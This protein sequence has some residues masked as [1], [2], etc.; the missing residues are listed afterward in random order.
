MSKSWDKK[1]EHH[2]QTLVKAT[3]H[4]IPKN[5]QKKFEQQIRAAYLL[6]KKSHQGQYRQ[7]GEPYIF[8]P[9]SVALILAEYQ[10]DQSTLQAALLHDTIEDTQ[11][12]YQNISQKF[13]KEV[14]N[15]V[16]GVTK[17]SE[18]AGF[19]RRFRKISTKE[20]LS[21]ETIRKIFETSE[22][23]IRII[24]LKIA[25]RL[26]NMRTLA[27]VEDPER[28]KK[29][30]IETQKIFLPFAKQLGLWKIKRELED[31]CYQYTEPHHYQVIQKFRQKTKE[32]KKEILN[33][34]LKKLQ[35]YDTEHLIQ[36]HSIYHHGTEFLIK[37]L[38]K[39]KILESPNNDLLLKLYV[40]NSRE[41][42]GL[43]EVIHRS[44]PR[45]LREQDFFQKKLHDFYQAYH[46][47]SLDHEDNLIEFRIITEEGK[48]RN[49]HGVAYDV[50][51]KF[52]AKHFQIEKSQSNLWKVFETVNLHTEKDPEAFLSATEKDVLSEK[53]EVFSN[54]KTYLIPRN[55]TTLDFAFFAFGREALYS[56]E[57]FQNGT[58]VDFNEI[59]SEKD[60]IQV[61]FSEK[62]TA[63]Y[64]WLYS[65]HTS[66][67]RIILQEYF[68]HHTQE[69]KIR[70]GKKILQKE[71]DLFGLGDTENFFRRYQKKLEEHGLQSSRDAL[72][73]FAEG[74]IIPYEIIE[75]KIKT[76][77]SK[78]IQKKYFL[79]NLY[80]KISQYFYPSDQ[81]EEKTFHLNIKGILSDHQN[82]L[83]KIEH[84][85][86]KYQIFSQKQIIKCTQKS[87]TFKVDYHGTAPSSKKLHQFIS[88]IA[89][90]PN[91]LNITPQISL[92]QKIILSLLL[93]INI[94]LWITVPFVESFLAIT[95]VQIPQIFLTTLI[96]TT[97]IPATLANF[98]LFRFIKT[99]IFQLRE[100]KIFIASAIGLN[101]LAFMLFVWSLITFHDGF[102]IS[103]VLTL[104]LIAT[105]FFTYQNIEEKYLQKKESPIKN[106]Q[107]M[108]FRQKISHN[109][110][111]I[112]GYLF[113]IGTI[114]A[115]GLAPII[116]KL[117][118]PDMN[119]FISV[120]IAYFVLGV[121]F[122]PL[123]LLKIIKKHKTLKE[124]PQKPLLNVSYNKLFWIAIIF[125]MLMIIFYFR[126]ID[127]TAASEIVLFLNFA[128][129]VALIISIIFFRNHFPYLKTKS[130]IQKILW[131]FYIGCIGAALLFFAKG[132][133]V[134]PSYQSSFYAITMLVFDV[135]ATIAILLYAKQKFAFS[136]WDYIFRKICFTALILTPIAIIYLSENIQHI[137]INNWIGILYLGFIDFL[138]GYWCAYEAYKRLDGLVNYLLLI[139]MPLLTLILEIFILGFRPNTL[140]F[141]G[142]AMILIS[143]IYAEIINSKAE[144]NQA[145]QVS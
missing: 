38:K 51:Q 39:E 111:K 12:N 41:A 135:I 127:L 104:F 94:G 52:T 103:I 119:S 7:S 96:Y 79:K 11:I 117:Y 105:A 100:K 6:A 62:I 4:Y 43:L 59:V 70:Y 108:N 54:K 66:T 123:I 60:H 116:V 143:A 19:S 28:K 32:Q 10:A 61:I 101:I 82:P 72:I 23:D 55:T 136:G 17:I 93:M 20:A 24:I 124:S 130:S 14:A 121:T 73:S 109:K 29:K 48:I 33:N 139:F 65:L 15:M 26:H 64:D 16:E 25:D 44:F 83:E 78:K 133:S 5:Q 110:Q 68:Q 21:I 40:K 145:P 85:Q 144:K 22:Q 142:A 30:S 8:H 84:L 112:Y 131:A 97:I 129:V 138:F 118:L 89:N 128:P 53:I 102:N 71:L 1:I 91:I 107:T 95:Q 134:T 3:H 58:K 57:I 81:E 87:K 115:F 88:A 27:A 113:R 77:P 99:Y 137:S 98:L 122:I 125:D 56:K 31:L 141:V 106:N 50:Y 120:S 45:I 13:G 35:S 47:R 69:E 42:F 74:R 90:E 37:K 132:N 76:D 49:M 2:F 75:E 18:V 92:R 67:G 114:V 126:G 46:I 63:K 34:A 36:S 80:R 140:F 86:N 9:I